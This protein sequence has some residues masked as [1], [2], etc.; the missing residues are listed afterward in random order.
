MG[1]KRYC[2]AIDLGASGGKMSK[3]VFDGESINIDNCI[4]FDNVPVSI[5]N[6]LYWDLFDLYKSII[7]GLTAFAAE[8]GE[9]ESIGIDTWG[10]T[11]GFLDKKGRLAEP[12]FHY[13]DMR[14]ETAL[15]DMYQKV[16][17]RDIF[18]L[19]G[20][21]C[22]RSYTLPQLFASVD[23]HDTVLDTA[24]KMLFLPDLLSYFLC[25]VKTTER[26]IAGT[27]AL[28]DNSQEGWSFE[29]LKKFD[30]PA[31]L[32]T[33][34]VE[35]GTVKGNITEKII[36]DTGIKNAKVVAVASHDSASA[37]AAIPGFGENN[38]YIS[39][40]TNISM[41]IESDTPG[42][43]DLFYGGGFKNTGGLMKKV[44]IYRDFAAFWILN[45]LQSDWRRRGIEYSFDQMN[46]MAE[47]AMNSSYLNLDDKILNMA[48]DAM[49]DKID[50]YLDMTNQPALH[51]HGEYVRCAFESIALKVKNTVE[52][53]KKAT[54][55]NFTGIYVISGGSR[56]KMLNRLIC[57]AVNTP[58]KAG[59][60]YATIAGNALAQLY[61][62][63]YASSLEQL[64]EISENSF[65]MSLYKP[66]K[67]KNWDE[68]LEFCIRIGICV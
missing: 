34:I 43:S 7:K 64:R 20:C 52:D 67:L 41:G 22:A 12:V 60:P 16:S 66:E 32:F 25:G 9:I 33:E 58:L 55:K 44:I 14:T 1:G 17:Q 6:N 46:H 63:G 13:R 28:L 61:A 45:E 35:A 15:E 59:L 11:Y 47:G 57:D 50:K 53:L 3:V 10:A 31:N 39:M 49:Q 37:V 5:N 62:N 48:G 27:S 68:A 54:G 23:Q 4:K 2:V 65:G 8:E 42:L 26:T 21:Q 18:D 29:L 30:I 51:S 38:I 56:N 36:R 40:G 24:D 19:T